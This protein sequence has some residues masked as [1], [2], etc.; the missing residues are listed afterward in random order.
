VQKTSISFKKIA[1]LEAATDFD[2]PFEKVL[3]EKDD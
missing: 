3:S 1:N 2:C